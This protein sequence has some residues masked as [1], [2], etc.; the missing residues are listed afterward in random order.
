MNPITN[1]QLCLLP[2]P[3]IVLY[4]DGFNLM[5]NFFPPGQYFCPQFLNGIWY[6]L[7]WEPLSGGCVFTI[8][9]F[10]PSGNVFTTVFTD[11]NV[12]QS[13]EYQISA[14]NDGTNLY[15][16]T[17]AGLLFTV[18]T[19][20]WQSGYRDLTNHNPPQTTW[21]GFYG[22]EHAQN[23]EFY[24]VRQLINSTNNTD[25][26][27]IRINYDTNTM[28]ATSFGVVSSLNTLPPG[29]NGWTINGGFYSSSFDKCN[30]TY[31]LTT[32]IELDPP[33]SHV[34]HIDLTAQTPSPVY[35]WVDGFVFGLQS[36]ESL[37]CCSVTE[38]CITDIWVSH[39][40]G[41]AREYGKSI[42]VDEDGFIFVTGGFNGDAVFP[43]GGAGYTSMGMTDMFV[44]KQDLAGDFLNVSQISSLGMDEGNA[45]L[46]SGSDVYVTGRFDNGATIIKLDYDLNV[47]WQ[48]DLIPTNGQASGNSLVIDE[49]GYVYV[50]GTFSGILDF[51]PNIYQSYDFVE[52]VFVVQLDP[53]GTVIWAKRIGGEG[54]DYG[55]GITIDQ[56][57][58]L[59]VTGDFVD[60]FQII[61]NA[62]FPSFGFASIGSTDVFLAKLNTDGIFDWAKRLGGAEY[63]HARS[64]VA[65]A[66]GDVFITG[67]F[68][69]HP[70]LSNPASSG[71]NFIAYANGGSR[72]PYLSKHS[73]LDGHSIWTA[74][75]RGTGNSVGSGLSLA[76]DRF[77]HKIYTA[78]L[79]NGAVNFNPGFSYS[80]LTSNPAGQ[81]MFVSILN[82]MDGS[83]INAFNMG[84]TGALNEFS[85]IPRIGNSIALDKSSCIHLTGGFIGTVD[86]DP[87]TNVLSNTAISAI[88]GFVQKFCNCCCEDLPTF[89]S[90]VAMGW[91]VVVDEA[92][93]QVTISADQFNDC[94]VMFSSA[95]DWGDG[96][97][98]FPS[99]F[100]ANGT[101]THTYAAPGSYDIC[102]SVGEISGVDCTD[103]LA[104]VCIP[105]T[106]NC[107]TP[108]CCLDI[109]DFHDEVSTL[110]MEWE[111]VTSYPPDCFT[112]TVALTLPECYG[113]LSATPDWG[114]GNGPTG[115]TTFPPIGSTTSWT[116]TYTQPGVY[117]VCIDIAEFSGGQICPG[118][119]AT[120]C[121]DLMVDDLSVNTFLIEDATL[122]NTPA[123]VY[124][125]LINNSAC[126]NTQVQWFVKECGSTDPF[127]NYYTS[128]G[129]APFPANPAAFGS[130]CIEVF[131]VVLFD[132]GPSCCGL[133]SYTTNVAQIIFCSPVPCS[134]QNPYL[135]FCGSAPPQTLEVIYAASSCVSSVEWFY[136]GVSI[137]TGTNT[138]VTPQ[139][140]F[141]ANAGQ[142][143]EDHVFTAQISSTCGV[144]SCQTTIRVFN[145][146]LQNGGLALAPLKDL[147]LCNGDDATVVFTPHPCI[148]QWKWYVSNVP[149]P[150]GLSDYDEMTQLGLNN[151]LLNTNILT[152]TTWYMV[153]GNNGPC[154]AMPAQ[155]E[156]PV[157][158]EINIVDFSV[159]HD[160]CL[161]T[162]DFVLEFTPAV[163]PGPAPCDYEVA[164]YLNG[165]Y[166]DTYYFTASPATLTITAN[167]NEFYGNFQAIIK[168]NCCGTEW[169][170][171]VIT[172]EPVC[173]PMVS[174][175]CYRCFGDTD[176]ITLE[177]SMMLP[178]GLPCNTPCTYQ[179]LDE[180]FNPILGANSL[181]YTS[182]VG[183][184]F[185][186]QSDC[187][188]CI[189]TTSIYVAD[190][191]QSCT[192]NTEE[193]VDLA[194]HNISIFPNPS[195]GV[196]TLKIESKPLIK[197]SLKVFNPQG[198][199]VYAKALPDG[200]NAH[201]IKLDF[202]P[203]G[204]YYIH[205]SAEN[206]PVFAR[207]VLIVK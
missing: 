185:Y 27:L 65:D 43:V 207:K 106:L 196:F 35:D 176:P 79:F 51:G 128:T 170:T 23:D 127:V 183:G 15:F 46:V 117:Q 124:I 105:V 118:H 182:N 152:E 44:S 76:F 42:A 134:M 86:F 115:G 149:N 155:L 31:I 198:K 169:E 140:D 104:S 175:P 144:S 83:F 21:S 163:H 40:G 12:H 70:S 55:N 174:G 6:V 29:P 172:I 137:A 188:G 156:I 142:C 101:W 48:T 63:E 81:D 153:T 41:T 49:N 94:Q 187:N 84:G 204:F 150:V 30:K 119:Q 10:D 195:A 47:V 62:G 205:V 113:L 7:G 114:D 93:C 73:G 121:V 4:Y 136:G 111:Q 59:F 177:A 26:D 52:D 24:L 186:F 58:N 32:P 159:T 64:I 1:E 161:E 5:H 165:V 191:D 120:L 200:L 148:P 168:D 14:T 129:L 20:T 99:T 184:M 98:S 145:P 72:D 60:D 38:P 85:D 34:I 92:N 143:F 206:L 71:F 157:K 139:F 189:K 18:N 112:Y 28:S 3:G 87:R 116:H 17:Q 181:T 131:A 77:E 180:H 135:E 197:A 173:E 201:E 162:L 147:P 16:L 90:L 160:P 123:P 164:G 97:I 146:N 13:C 193:P 100:P 202:L 78:G 125:P 89:N 95:P 141:P 19:Q 11:T 110:Q 107:P 68:V 190:C 171:S 74:Q 54:P 22:I 108:N 126:V 45:I 91:D 80:A 178:N 151:T 37:G 199:E 167:S 25:W 8:S 102:F 75:L 61:Q 2:D 154:P 36:S 67:H 53:G 166:M 103:F 130:D 39:I 57:H 82:P 203:A 33:E 192:T 69:N 194:C 96:S 133:T 66:N 50:I 9:T 88:D 109:Q 132:G 179:W 122:C 158:A 56:Q 138:I